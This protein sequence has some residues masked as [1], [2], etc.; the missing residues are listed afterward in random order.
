M[1]LS[2]F[3]S[4]PIAGAVSAHWWPEY[5]QMM[6]LNDPG[7]ATQLSHI[8]AILLQ[9]L[10]ENLMQFEISLSEFRLRTDFG[11]F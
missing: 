3:V 9:K 11:H 8:I 6:A 4:F 10:Q 1:P 7:P 2:N 5:G